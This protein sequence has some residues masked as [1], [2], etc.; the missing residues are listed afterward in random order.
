MT[1]SRVDES[2]AIVHV[3]WDAATCTAKNYHLVYGQ[4]AGLASYALDGG[5]CG[6]GPLGSYDWENVP[7]GDLWFLAIGD[8][9]AAAEGSWGMSQ[10][11]A[12]RNGTTASGACGFATR[13]NAGTCP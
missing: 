6:L 4:L 7:A 12:E 5:V 1:A 11:P 8:D 10:P 9:A 13:T 2:G 3:A